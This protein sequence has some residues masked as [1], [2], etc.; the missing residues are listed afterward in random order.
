MGLAAECRAGGRRGQW[1]G[2]QEESSQPWRCSGGEEGRP[3]DRSR[4]MR[5]E[6]EQWSAWRGQDSGVPE[7]GS[8]RATGPAGRGREWTLDFGGAVTDGPRQ[9]QL[10]V[11]PSSWR[12][13]WSPLTRI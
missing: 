13:F 1:L 12:R 10:G 11:A 5:E 9:V 7:R 8:W 6:P 4:G 3:E 2:L